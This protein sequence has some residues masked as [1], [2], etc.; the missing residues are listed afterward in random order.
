MGQS[1]RVPVSGISI[2]KAYASGVSVVR[3]RSDDSIVAIAV[4]E[5]EKEEEE[6]SSS[7]QSE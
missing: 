4:T 6:E 1:I 3:L 2:Q 7:E 5:S